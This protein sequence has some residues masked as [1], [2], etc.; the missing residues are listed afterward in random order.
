MW[1]DIISLIQLRRKYPVLDTYA[2]WIAAGIQRLYVRIIGYVHVQRGR[3]RPIKRW[4][5]EAQK[6]CETM[7]ITLQ[8][9]ISRAL[10]REKWRKYIMELP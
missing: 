1:Q 4:M 7:D 2:G 5:D 6:Y 8:G 9:A 3:G 10:N